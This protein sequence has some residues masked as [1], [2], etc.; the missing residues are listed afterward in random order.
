MERVFFEH[1][2]RR[3]T[4]VLSRVFLKQAL[5]LIESLCYNIPDMHEM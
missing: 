5:R 4:S 3:A 2:P 1:L